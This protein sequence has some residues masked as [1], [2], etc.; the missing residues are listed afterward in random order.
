MIAFKNYMRMDTEFLVSHSS[1]SNPHRREVY[2]EFPRHLSGPTS[3]PGRRAALWCVKQAGDEII[4][5]EELPVSDWTWIYS[6]PTWQ[7]PPIC[8]QILN[9][10]FELRIIIICKE[11]KEKSDEIKKLMLNWV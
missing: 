8:H 3:W 10:L 9:L 11:S 4:A 1:F 6:D 5:K 2:A 7:K